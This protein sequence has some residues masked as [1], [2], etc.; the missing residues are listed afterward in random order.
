MLAVAAAHGVRRGERRLLGDADEVLL[1]QP[2]EADRAL[3]GRSRRAGG[4]AHRAAVFI[5]DS[6][7]IAEVTGGWNAGMPVM[8]SPITRPWMSW[9]PS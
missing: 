4:V 7:A 9:V 6:R 3:A 2:L 1:E 8:A 5:A